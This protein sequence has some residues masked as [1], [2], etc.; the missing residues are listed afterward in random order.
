M[1]IL[2]SV[3]LIAACTSPEPEDEIDEVDQAATTTPPLTLARTD[4][5]DGYVTSAATNGTTLY[6]GGNF[7][8][9]GERSGELALVSADTGTRDKSITELGGGGV[10][11]IV[12]DGSGG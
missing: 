4:V 2:L 5:T 8:Y 10:F 11:A 9:I 12:A 6:I 1:R 3:L 7:R